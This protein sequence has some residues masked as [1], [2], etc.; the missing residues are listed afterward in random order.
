ML[1]ERIASGAGGFVPHLKLLESSGRTTA[2]KTPHSAPQSARIIRS[3]TATASGH[4]QEAG[5]SM[6]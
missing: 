3:P 4:A 1:H 6:D 2:T 5:L